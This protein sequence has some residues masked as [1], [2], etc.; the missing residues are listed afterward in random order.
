MQW[1][2]GLEGTLDERLRRLNTLTHGDFN[3]VLAG[4]QIGNREKPYHE[5]IGDGKAIGPN[6]GEYAEQGV[7]SGGGI[8]MDT[9]AGDPVE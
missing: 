2:L 9:V 5:G 1:P 6:A 3:G 8:D 7:L 4:R